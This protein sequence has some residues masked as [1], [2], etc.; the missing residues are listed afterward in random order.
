MLRSGSTNAKQREL[1]EMRAR[2][3]K[4]IART[5]VNFAEALEAGNEARADLEYA[6]RKM[7][8]LRSHAKSE[9]ADEYET[10]RSSR[11]R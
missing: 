6:D 2:M 7:A 5:R 8:A 3:K 11:K 10:A 1:E 4:R 9:Y